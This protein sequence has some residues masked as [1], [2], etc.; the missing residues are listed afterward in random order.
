MIALW[1]ALGRYRHRSDAVSVIIILSA[2]VIV[3]LGWRQL[4]T[5]SYWRGYFTIL[6]V[7]A[8]LLV[9]VGAFSAI[10]ILVLI[11]LIAMAIDLFFIAPH[12]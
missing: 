5:N 8:G 11:A 6:L 12:R 1:W 7:F 10:F 9:F 2:A 3:I 4:T